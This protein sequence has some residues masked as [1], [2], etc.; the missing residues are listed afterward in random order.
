ME[1]WWFSD[2]YRVEFVVAEVW[3][4]IADSEVGNDKV[5]SPC[6]RVHPKTD[7]SAAIS[8]V[9]SL[10]STIVEVRVHMY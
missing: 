3:P 9:D 6:I 10:K 1:N 2:V 5:H 4:S 8:V 7:I